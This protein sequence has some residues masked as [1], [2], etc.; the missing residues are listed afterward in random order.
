MLLNS[1]DI[2]GPL[3]FSVC[4]ALESYGKKQ[5]ATVRAIRAAVEKGIGMLRVQSEEAAGML[6][7]ESAGRQTAADFVKLL[8]D[9]NTTFT[10][11]LV[12]VTK[13]GE[14]MKSA[15]FLRSDA[16]PSADLMLKG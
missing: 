4:F 11:E 7:A 16:A 6:A 10:N 13:L 14:F 9:P 12:G 3:T 1:R 15:G 5:P 2:V 8:S